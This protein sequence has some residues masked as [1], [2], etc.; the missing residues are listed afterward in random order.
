MNRTLDQILDALGGVQMVTASL[1]CGRSAVSNWKRNGRLP[2]ARV[3]E[4]ADM[5][6]AKGIPIS[7]DEIRCAGETAS[8]RRVAA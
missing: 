1:G 4:L 8:S 6:K 5:A 3:L 2:P 7:L